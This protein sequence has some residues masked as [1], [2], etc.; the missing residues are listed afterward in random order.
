MCVNVCLCVF[1]CECVCACVV[2]VRVCACARLC[3]NNVLRPSASGQVLVRQRDL[4]PIDCVPFLC[5]GRPR[6]CVLRWTTENTPRNDPPVHSLT[7]PPTHPQRR[8]D[9]DDDDDHDDDDD[10]KRIRHPELAS[11]KATILNQENYNQ[12][13]AA[14]SLLVQEERTQLEREIANTPRLQSILHTARACTPTVMGG[15]HQIASWS[16]R[17]KPKD[18]AQVAN[19][20]RCA[21]QLSATRVS[22][23][24]C[25]GVFCQYCAPERP[26]LMAFR[27]P[28][29]VTAAKFVCWTCTCVLEYE[30]PARRAH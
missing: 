9:D 5:G 19:C 30:R 29:K 8:R 22:C 1:M 10:N 27:V 7:H 23:R 28:E 13:L 18:M 26:C 11:F 14:I 15:A 3:Q 6:P 12:W 17:V 20:T 2:R 4:L 25:C 16:D 21:A 24:V